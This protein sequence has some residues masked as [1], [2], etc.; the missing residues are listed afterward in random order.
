MNKLFVILCIVSF[1]V[2]NTSCKESIVSLE[3]MDVDLMRRAADQRVQNLI[4]QARQ[5]DVEAY[6]S[7]ALCYRDGDGVDK[8]WL[9]MI[10]MYLLYSQKAGVDIEEIIENFDVEHPFR[11]LIEIL[12]LPSF[13]ENIEENMAQLK[14]VAPIEAKAIEVAGNFLS[15]ENTAEAVATMREVEEEGSE[16]AAVFQVIYYRDAKD[17]EG[18]EECLIRIAKKYP[19]FNLQLGDVY[20]ERYSEDEDFTNIQKAIECY[21]K[22]DAYGMLDPTYANSLLGMYEYFGQKGLLESDEQEVERLKI[23]ATRIY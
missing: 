8:S 23:L 17:K 21:Y 10:F 18:E 14:V 3:N 6:N 12:G 4:Q 20:V 19:L 7:L 2:F 15:M 1:L 22:A 13:N 16:I 5:G 11:L 9:N